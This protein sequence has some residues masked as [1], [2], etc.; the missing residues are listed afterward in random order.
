MRSALV[1]ICFC[2]GTIP[3]FAQNQ[4]GNQG[5]NCQGQIC[6]APAPIIGF[7]IPS[8]LAVGGVLLGAKLLS[9]NKQT[10]K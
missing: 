2:I 1:V 9:R 3:A 5:G 6:G 4:G 7:G 8:A 10:K